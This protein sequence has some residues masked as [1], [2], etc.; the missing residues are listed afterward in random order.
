[1]YQYSFGKIERKLGYKL[2]LLKTSRVKNAN[3]AVLSL[4]RQFSD[5][6]HTMSCR[7]ILA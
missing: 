4:G 6:G 3:F 1:M 7:T 5:N 2:K